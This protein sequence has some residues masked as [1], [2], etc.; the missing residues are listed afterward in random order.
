MQNATVIATNSMMETFGVW[1]LET[2]TA[3]KRTTESP[4]RA[5]EAT[6]QAWRGT[7]LEKGSLRGG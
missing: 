7:H 5:I 2:N 3:M 6:C 4:M 1:R